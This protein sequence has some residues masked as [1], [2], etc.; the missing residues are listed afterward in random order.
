MLTVD[1]VMAKCTDSYKVRI[2]NTISPTKNTHILNNH[3]TLPQRG[4]QKKTF[5]PVYLQLKQTEIFPTEGTHIPYF[6]NL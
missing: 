4:I 1:N 6:C 2:L 3:Q 5:P